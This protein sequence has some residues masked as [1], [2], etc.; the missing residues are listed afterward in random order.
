MTK[1][2]IMRKH[3]YTFIILKHYHDYRE[4]YSTM[5]ALGK[6]QETDPKVKLSVAFIFSAM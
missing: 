5:Q 6:Y 4:K 3:S 1:H 2:I